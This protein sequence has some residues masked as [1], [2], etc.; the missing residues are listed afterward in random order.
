M[1]NILRNNLEL[2]NA[3]SIVSANGAAQILVD[4]LEGFG[5]VIVATSVTGTSPTFDM[6]IQHSHDGTN[7]FDLTTFTQITTASS[8]FKAITGEVLKYIRYSLVAGGTTPSANLEVA[9]CYN[10]K[11]KR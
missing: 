6:K 11:K 7:W 8:E 3:V 4:D 5:A 2:L 9:F 1:A 10:D